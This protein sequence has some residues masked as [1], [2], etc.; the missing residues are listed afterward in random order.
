[1]PSMGIKISYR[2]DFDAAE[3]RLVC[4]ALS[5]KLEGKDIVVANNLANQITKARASQVK[6][7]LEQTEKLAQNLERA[8]N[9]ATEPKTDAVE[10]A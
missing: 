9:E 8:E 6:Q 1:M 4:K 5:G 10:E 2:M 7:M 3:L